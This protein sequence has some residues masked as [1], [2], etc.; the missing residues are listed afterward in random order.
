LLNDKG[1]LW[2]VNPTELK[3]V[4]VPTCSLSILVARTDIPFMMHTIPHLVKMCNYPFVEKLLVVDAGE[5]SGDYPK[6]PGIGTLE[7]L[8]ECCDRLLKDGVMDRAVD[9][10]FSPQYRDRMYRKHFQGQVQET[11]N[12][13]GAPV[14]GYI[15][16]IEEAKGDYVLYFDCDMLLHQQPGFNWIAEGIQL[17]EKHPE[18]VDVLPLASPPSEGKEQAYQACELHAD[19]FYSLKRFTSRK[20]LVNRQ[21]FEQF[22]P[23]TVRWLPSR[24]KPKWLPGAIAT[25]ISAV[26]GKG[27]LERWENMM[28]NR[29]Q[30]TNYVR[31]DLA[32]PKAWTLHPHKHGADF[33]A[34]LPKLIEKVEAGWYPPEQAGIYDLNLEPWLQY[35]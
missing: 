29:L 23:L 13:R 12:Y 10:D 28:S 17:M 24:Q 6:R 33:V 11:H 1:N 20:F 3:T 25:K 22:L 2:A 15:A 27:G 14:L 32:N 5:L 19:G 16:C 8:R 9:I 7:Q 26:T 18:I 31:A 35:L 21:R 4:S 34:A 30:A